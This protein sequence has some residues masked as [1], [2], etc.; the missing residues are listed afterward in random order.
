MRIEL[1]PYIPPLCDGASIW[2]ISESIR[3]PPHA[4]RTYEMD[5]M[6][7]GAMT[8]QPADSQAMRIHGG[9]VSI[10]QPGVVHSCANNL[11]AHCTYFVAGIR[12]PLPVPCPPLADEDIP[13]VTALL[14]NSG[15][16]I[17]RASRETDAS[18]VELLNACRY[19]LELQNTAWYKAWMGNLVDRMLICLIRSLASPAQAPQYK[20]VENARRLLEENLSLPLGIVDVARAVGLQPSQLARLFRL[21]TGQSPAEYRMRL[22]VEAAAGELQHSSMSI[23][24]I[25]SLFSFSNNRHFAGTFRKYMHMTPSAWRQMA[26]GEK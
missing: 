15:N 24:R 8:F 20:A 13:A 6:H 3:V 5:Y 25:A 26:R 18:F 11:Q 23:S 14:Q 12:A 21:A 7:K 9:D 22:R 2:I 4:Q 16:R 10:V 19:P 1:K 17:V